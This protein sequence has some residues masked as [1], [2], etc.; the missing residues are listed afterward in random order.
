MI[1]ENSKTTLS[2]LLNAAFRLYKEG[3]QKHLEGQ[4]AIA[5]RLYVRALYT[6]MDPIAR[7]VIYYNMGVIY[8]QLNEKQKALLHLN[9]SLVLNPTNTA[10]MNHIAVIY[11]QIGEFCLNEGS[12]EQSDVFFSRAQQYWVEATLQAPNEYLQAENWLAQL[13]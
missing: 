5:F 10:A 6:E 8:F 11:H 1:S 3:F 4:Y 13:S 2:K 9:Q 12:L 7:S